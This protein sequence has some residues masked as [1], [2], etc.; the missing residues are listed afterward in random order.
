[1]CHTWIGKATDVG[2]FPASISLSISLQNRWRN[3]FLSVENFSRISRVGGR[4]SGRSMVLHF[5]R[6]GPERAMPAGASVTALAIDW[7]C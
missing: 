4:S 7:P 2:S 3:T 5:V 1:M 6:I